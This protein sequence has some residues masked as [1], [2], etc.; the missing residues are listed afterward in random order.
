MARTDISVCARALMNLGASPINSFDDPGDTAK[1][2]KLAYPEIRAGVIA[3]YQ[4]ECMKV[5]KE[6]TRQS[7]A[8]S[9]FHFQFLFPGE[10]IGAPIAV[11]W[12]DQPWVRATAGYEI[13]GRRILSNYERLWCEFVVEKP[14]AEWPSW[15][16][17]LMV[18][19]IASE[20]AFMVTDQ[21]NVKDYWETKTYGTPSENRVGG[22]IG[23][24]MT[25]DAQGSGN[26]PGLSDSAFVDARFGAVYPGDQW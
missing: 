8:P 2:L 4:W 1:F 6:L 13:R 20:I 24:A 21:Q 10:L 3:S 12:S 22:L 18:G 15:F 9:G 7:D 25:L 19:A 16:A 14:E 17:D 23:T 26:N 11:Y 5:R